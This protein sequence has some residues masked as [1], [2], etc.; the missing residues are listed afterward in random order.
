MTAEAGTTNDEFKSVDIGAVETDAT[1]VM[2]KSTAFIQ[3][4]TEESSTGMMNVNEMT[5]K[6]IIKEN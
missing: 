3:E 6:S 1:P 5:L 4:T 2:K